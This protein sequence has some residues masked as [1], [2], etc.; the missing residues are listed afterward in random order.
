MD[1]VNYVEITLDKPRKLRFQVVETRDACRRLG[2]LSFMALLARLNEADLESLS[3]MLWKGLGW[4]DKRLTLDAVDALVQKHI[5]GGGTLGDLLGYIT[6]GLAV[7]GL[8]RRRGAEGNES[9][10]SSSG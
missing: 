5:D 9:S 3:V 4:E 10:A 8:I 6:E 2:N 1:A 7:S